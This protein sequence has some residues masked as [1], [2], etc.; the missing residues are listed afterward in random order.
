MRRRLL[1]ALA[2]CLTLAVPVAA[3]QTVTSHGI[4]P[5]GELK[6]PADFA[7]FDYVNPDAP[8]GG[9]MSFR[10]TGASGTFDSLNAFILA[11]E[12]AQGL[13]RVYDALLAP[14][15]DEP[16]A[17]YGLVAESLEYPPDRSWVTFT[18][19]EGVSFSDGV[20]LTAEDVVWTLETLKTRG[21]P[22]Y[23][24]AL[25][26]VESVEAP[27]PR[28]VT[29]RFAAGANTRDL[30]AEV[31]STPILPK[32]YY[33]SRDF[34][35]S[36]LEIPVGSGPYVVAGA[37]PGRRIRYCRNPGY[38]GADLPVNVGA[39]N[40]DCFVYEYFADTTAAFE[41]LKVG[42]YLF[43]E[44]F[45]SAIWATGYDFP[46]LTKGW[47]VRDEIPDA[48][49]S[50]TQGFWFNLR[51]EKFADPRVREAI[52]ILFNFEWSN[53]SLFHG[54]YRRTDS[55]WENAAG[56]QAEGLPEGA[57]LAA[58]EPLR[59]Q[60]PE[61]VFTGPA[62][63]PPVW[64][65]ERPADRRALRQAAALLEAAGW[66]VGPD[67]W[68]RNPAGE[69]LT[70]VFLDD[71][72]AIQRIL[73][74]YVQS[75]RQA[76][77]DA[78]VELVDFAQ[79]Q[80]RQKNFDYDLTSVRLAM[81]MAPSVELRTLFGSA[82]ADQPGT[83]NVSG[84]ADP[85]VDALIEAVIAAPDRARME[86]RVRAL[87]RVL[88][89]RRIWVPNWYAG[90]YRVAYWDIFGRPDVQPPFDRGTDFWWL[91]RTRLD[92]LLAAG[93]PRALEAAR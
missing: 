78:R 79:M 83:L 76:G 6:Y 50:G 85:A 11:G 36:T 3:Q 33:E 57:E 32:H 91:D 61:E 41:A 47:V 23:R 53:E 22:Y 37:Q 60:L 93:A 80:E 46:A 38:W 35:R 21:H 62:Y 73:D 88:R 55:F 10:G 13:G 28:H 58:L 82:S 64:S 17:W 4:S 87:D 42:D 67:G 19:R 5:F 70:V 84:L 2:C 51:R 1:P 86:A 92:R 8:K 71:S 66:R 63:V 24:I 15:A 43:H 44:E 45:S 90:V 39:N 18:L 14:A 65:P 72:T 74:P 81:S 12:P 26:Q 48:R 40:F 49:P 52:A 9:T 77:I 54:L 68:R 30:P 29:V 16:G 56:L 59:D 89:A 75:L 31:G 25:A 27:D 7:H 34:T 69:A 20:P